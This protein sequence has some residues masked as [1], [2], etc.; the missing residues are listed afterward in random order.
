MRLLMAW[1]GL[2]C[3][4]GAGSWT[5]WRPE[6]LPM[7]LAVLCLALLA[8]LAPTPR[9][10][11][12]ALLH[13]AFLLG[14]VVPSLARAPAPPGGWTSIQGEVVSASGF[15]ATVLT[16]E[17]AWALRF[18]ERAPSRGTRLAAWVHPQP[19]ET[20]LPGEPA[21]AWAMQTGGARPAR[22]RRWVELGGA[23]GAVGG[24]GVD[25][26][27]VDGP[28]WSLAEHGGLLRA[29]ATGERAGVDD[30]TEALLRRTGTR[31]LLAISGLHLG[32]VAAGVAGVVGWLGR[33][34]LSGWRPG[35]VHIK[36]SLSRA[37]ST[38]VAAS[39]LMSPPLGSGL[40]KTR[41]TSGSNGRG[42]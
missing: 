6:G 31:H 9:A 4:L 27:G 5:S 8:V 20:L 38:G 2:A 12:L 34:L 41:N 10:S 16:G 18:S 13:A 15:G 36:S 35:W 3:V 7:A 11:A 40:R 30:R 28:D 42:P 17:G 14:A 25:G 33:L 19:G 26:P 29:L 32:L 23:A 37:Q 21:R 24:P 22:V 39:P 1:C